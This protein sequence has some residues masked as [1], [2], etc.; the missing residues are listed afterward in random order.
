M[1]LADA[2]TGQDRIALLPLRASS[3][4]SELWAKQEYFELY[5]RIERVASGSASPS[6]M[7][8]LP[9]GNVRS[10]SQWLDTSRPT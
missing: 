9:D 7:V 4:A 1:G 2:A 5:A 3:S 10:L 6:W 8:Y